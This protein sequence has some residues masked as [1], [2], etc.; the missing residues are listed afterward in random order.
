M[1]TLTLEAGLV[2]KLQNTAGLTALISTRVYLERIPQGATVPC[3][4]YQRISTTR[5]L[6]HDV[7]GSAGTARVRVQFD[8]W[9][10]TYLS[11]KAIAD[12]LRAALNGFKGTITSGSDTV[13]VQAAL[14]EAESSEPDLDAELSRVRSDYFIWHLEA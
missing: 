10:T 3:L 5:E 11:A 13:V 2:Y 12:A 6:T 9:A 14:I 4:T 7:S 8:A 1:G